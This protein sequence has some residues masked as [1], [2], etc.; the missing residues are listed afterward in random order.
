MRIVSLEVSGYRSLQ[1]CYID[2]D[3][4]LTVLVGKNDSGKSTIIKAIDFI[5]HVLKGESG[6]QFTFSGGSGRTPFDHVFNNVQ[7]LQPFFHNKAGRI[8][9][10]L[11]FELT[12]EDWNHVFGFPS[13]W[14]I[15]GKEYSESGIGN[16]AVTFIIV[17]SEKPNLIHAKVSEISSI[18]G[19]KFYLE[20]DPNPKNIEYLRISYNPNSKEFNLTAGGRDE[21]PVTRLS[22]VITGTFS[23][24]SIG[25]P[26]ERFFI[27]PA[28]RVIKS[29]RN[30]PDFPGASLSV[31][32]IDNIP[33]FVM[34]VQSKSRANRRVSLQKIKNS[35]SEI[36]PEYE[37]IKAM[38]DN[39]DSTDLFIGDYRSDQIGSGAKQILYAIF[40]I[41][42]ANID[43]IAIEE[44]EVHLHPEMQREFFRFLLNHLS[45]TQLIVTT[46]SSVIVGE[47][48][49]ESIRLVSKNEEGLTSVKKIDY[50]SV[51]AI[52]AELG[53]Q[54]KDILDFT[55]FLFVEGERD[56]I[57]FEE[58]VKRFSIKGPAGNRIAVIDVGGWGNYGAMSNSKVVS[59]LGRPFLCVFDG[60][61][62]RDASKKEAKEKFI[63]NSKILTSQIVTL[64]KPNIEHYIC[65]PE[66]L[67]R[68]YPELK[69][70][71]V[72]D[73]QLRNYESRS[74][75]KNE[76]NL[77][78]TKVFK[79]G[80]NDDD[81]RLIVLNLKDD[82]IPKEMQSF[83]ESLIGSK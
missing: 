46:H 51:S 12:N 18:G 40:G 60:D 38:E 16:L 27:I 24:S 66:L 20:K 78:W 63:R 72:V 59:K 65:E 37:D 50:G 8:T 54:I 9:G 56:A 15:N 1:N 80:F 10:K 55:A 4:N 61:T 77:I 58:I 49:I 76:L 6:N 23:D 14:T 36:F 21:S 43:I 68:V 64:L 25:K 69:D 28:E 44:P 30:S 26:R 53:T 31:K 70:K 3:R 45:D 33:E 11:V 47:S 41:D 17:A 73:E 5:M 52:S 13:P 74:D 62:E 29:Q 34:T 7:D 19:V 22:E 57:Y 83:L 67:R 48:P 32:N 71:S 39:P 42:V 2:L 79:R 82:E 81:M 35:L 75:L